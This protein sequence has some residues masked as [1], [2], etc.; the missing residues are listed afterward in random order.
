MSLTPGAQPPAGYIYT[1]FNQN[2]GSFGHYTNTRTYLNWAYMSSS[3]NMVFPCSWNSSGDVNGGY[4]NFSAT[5]GVNATLSGYGTGSNSNGNPNGS[6][7]GSCTVP[8]SG[9][10]SVAQN[11]NAGCGSSSG[12]VGGN[13]V[14]QPQIN[15]Y[16]TQISN[17]TNLTTIGPTYN[18]GTYVDLVR[19][20]NP[21]AV[22]GQVYYIVNYGV[23]NFAGVMSYA[24]EAIDGFTNGSVYIPQWACL[25]VT[26]NVAGTAWYI[27][28]YYNGTLPSS[29][30]YS[31]NGTTITSPI[32]TMSN[33]SGTA[34][35]TVILPNQATWGQGNYLFYNTYQTANTANMNQ[36]AM[37]TNGYLRQNTTANLYMQFYTGAGAD[38]RYDHNYSVAFISDGTWW[39]I[40]SVFDGQYM[41]FDNATNAGYS[42][43]SAPLVFASVIVCGF[44][45]RTSTGLS[46]QSGVYPKG[47]L[48]YLKYTP[49][50]YGQTYGLV[51]GGGNGSGYCGS[52]NWTRFY[53]SSGTAAL[54]TYNAYPMIQANISGTIINFPVGMYPSAY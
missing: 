47:G 28:S 10:F 40:T 41:I 39:Y 8:S 34:S 23:N 24:G 29:G 33:I 9:N 43:P 38:G 7:N 37:Y 17:N 46:E 32:V 19:L 49:G 36:P 15:F 22:I 45:T 6:A 13:S 26:P 48:S 3:T 44:P 30:V 12:Y 52:T 18:G 51:V 21:S 5:S 27:L 16:V 14:T 31:I 25:C 11:Q 35:R 50:Y 2:N 4:W 54:V 20:P 53:K 42:S 1:S